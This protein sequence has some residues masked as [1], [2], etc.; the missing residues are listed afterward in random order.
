M[1]MIV[2]WGTTTITN[3]MRI[4]QIV[5]SWNESC[6]CYGDQMQPNFNGDVDFSDHR[7]EKPIKLN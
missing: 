7:L 5:S 6:V 3:E 4:N 1:V 2:E